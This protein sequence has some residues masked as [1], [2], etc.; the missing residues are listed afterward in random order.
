MFTQAFCVSDQLRSEQGPFSLTCYCISRHGHASGQAECMLVTHQIWRG[1]N[2]CCLKHS[3]P[4]RHSGGQQQVSLANY[5]DQNPLLQGAIVRGSRAA[6][7]EVI[8]CMRMRDFYYEG[9]N[10]KAVN[11][12]QL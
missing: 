11:K 6:A 10:R 4:T 12:C 3:A 1:V 2:T 9:K 7:V 5:R 8:L